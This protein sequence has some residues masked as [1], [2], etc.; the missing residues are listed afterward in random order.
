VLNQRREVVSQD[1][2][3]CGSIQPQ[4]VAISNHY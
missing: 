3:A 4:V 2:A 1:P